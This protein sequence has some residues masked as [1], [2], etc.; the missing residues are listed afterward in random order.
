LAPTSGQIAQQKSTLWIGIN[1]NQAVTTVWR[2]K[3]GTMLSI[4]L[5]LPHHCLYGLLPLLVASSRMPQQQSSSFVWSRVAAPLLSSNCSQL[6]ESRLTRRIQVDAKK[7]VS[8]PLERVTT[9]R[10]AESR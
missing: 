5:E 10:D 1:L 6:I 2:T 8:G 4:G 7:A 3:P 9:R